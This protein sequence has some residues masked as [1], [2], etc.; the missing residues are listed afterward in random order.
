MALVPTSPDAIPHQGSRPP[1]RLDEEIRARLRDAIAGQLVQAQ[2][3]V[4]LLAGAISDAVAAL[5]AGLWTPAIAAGG[6]QTSPDPRAVADRLG[7]TLHRAPS[8]HVDEGRS[9]A[10]E[11]LSLDPGRRLE[12]A[13]RLA[14]T[15]AAARRRGAKRVL[16]GAGS[17]PLDEGGLSIDEARGIVERYDLELA[18][19]LAAAGVVEA[20]GAVPE[21]VHAGRW[22]GRRWPCWPLREA[23]ADRL[24]STITWPMRPLGRKDPE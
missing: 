20:M 14:A 24:S 17:A 22:R 4:V 12:R 2:A 1:P 19:P 21:Q 9:V 11:E 15:A 16:V 7:L 5:G 13:S 23:F 6:P 18:A 3:D 8:W 10:H